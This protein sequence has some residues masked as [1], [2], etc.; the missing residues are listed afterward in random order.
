MPYDEDGNFIYPLPARKSKVP[1]RPKERPRPGTLPPVI[2]FPT[3]APATPISQPIEKPLPVV[4]V[5]QTSTPETPVLPLTPTA[6]P[7]LTIQE[8]SNRWQMS[9]N[10]LALVWHA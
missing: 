7:V 3:P 6:Q 10:D 8:G 5:E 4:P 9:E 2:S 1:A